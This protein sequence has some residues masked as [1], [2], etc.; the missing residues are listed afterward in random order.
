METCVCVSQYF[1]NKQNVRSFGNILKCNILK[2]EPNF[3]KHLFGADFIIEELTEDLIRVLTKI[4]SNLRNKCK[5]DFRE[6]FPKNEFSKKLLPVEKDFIVNNCIKGLLDVIPKN[7]FG[8]NHNIKIF[9]TMVHK[10]IYS[11]KRQHFVLKVFVD[12]WDMSISPWNSLIYHDNAK[13]ILC[14]ILLWIF[15]NVLSAMICLNFYVTTCKLD[16]DEHKLFYFW[17][18][19]WHSFYD[20][21]ISDMMFMRII[22]RSKTYGFGKKAKRKFLNEKQNLKCVKKDVPKLHLVLKPNNEYRP[23]VRY[24]SK[25]LNTSEKYKMKEKLYFLKTLTGKPVTRIESDFFTVYHK[26]LKFDKPKLYF[27][28]TDLSNAFGSIIKEKLINILNEKHLMYQKTE[29]NVHL[30]KKFVQ[31]YKDIIEELR[32]PLLVRAGSTVFEWE[33]GLVQGYKYSPALSDLYYTYLDNIYFSEQLKQSVN[34]IKFFMR[35][36]DDYL[37]IT[38]SL[39]DAYMFLNNLSNYRNVN[40]EKTVVN[41]PH[42]SIK[43]NEDL[44]FLGYNYNTTSL[45]VGRANNIYMGQMCY[46]IAF[47]SAVGDVTKFLENRIG[48]SA[49]QINSHIFNLH[50]N[51]E[52][53]VWRYIFITFCLSANKFCTILAVLCNEG[54]MSN[55]LLT[56]KK[57]VT[58][59]MSNAIIESLSR[60]K[61]NDYWFVYCINHFRYLSWKALLLCAQK[62]PKCNGLIPLINI[63]LAKTNCIFGKFREHG[64]RIASDGE[65]YRQA[66]KEI[67]RR[68]DLRV[69]MRNFEIFPH[70]FECYNHKK[71]K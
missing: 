55:F 8:N 65:N 2:N 71:L 58:V 32:K 26:W 5:N 67:C 23:I 14:T 16:Y 11:M 3:F 37:Y 6:Y 4:K 61:P 30:K 31:Q 64:S 19:E 25:T 28:K 15:R 34:S 1:V 35:V 45:E 41:F 17:K 52:E 42:E 9:K 21:N 43:F 18:N 63:E 39:D 57:K 12:K 38:D 47:T 48:K 13:N 22:K 44:T 33:E 66:I 69:I 20:R 68:T 50:Y 29:K 51:K 54:E 46:K 60:N 59:K 24:K 10:I 40:Y 49:I 7:Y 53:T 56:Y 70:G 27:I 62:T 36:V